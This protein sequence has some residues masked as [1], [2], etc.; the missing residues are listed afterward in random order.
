ML[1]L[2]PSA[3]SLISSLSIKLSTNNG[4][5]AEMRPTS[6]RFSYYGLLGYLARLFPRIFRNRLMIPPSYARTGRRRETY[7]RHGSKAIADGGE[8][9]MIRAAGGCVISCAILAKS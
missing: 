5:E 8:L 4:N 6:M 1:C 2:S 7:E 3:V 9:A